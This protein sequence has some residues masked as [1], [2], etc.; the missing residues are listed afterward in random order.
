[1]YS[2]QTKLFEEL[3]I[4]NH[5]EMCDYITCGHYGPHKLDKECRKGYCMFYCTIVECKPYSE[6]KYQCTEK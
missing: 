1:M 3:Y 2:E 6:G 4:C 5:Y